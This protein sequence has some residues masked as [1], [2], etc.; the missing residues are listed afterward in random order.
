M[1]NATAPTHETPRRLADKVV[2]VSGGG[3]GIGRAAA[4]AYARE[5]AKVALA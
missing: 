2:L 1:I 4:L 3:T 5:G